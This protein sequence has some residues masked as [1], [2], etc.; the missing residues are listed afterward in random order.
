M[1]GHPGHVGIKDVMV[2][3]VK[4]EKLVNRDHMDIWVRKVVMVMRAIKEIR[5]I[6]ATMGVRVKKDVRDLSVRSVR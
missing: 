1:T 5:E 2:H 6:K 3:P 4:M